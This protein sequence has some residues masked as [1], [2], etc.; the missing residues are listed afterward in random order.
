MKRAGARCDARIYPNAAH[1]FFNRDPH[2]TLTLIEA[3]KFLA[4]LGWLRGNPS[5]AAP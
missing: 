5:L 2:F 4:S 1:G 3:D